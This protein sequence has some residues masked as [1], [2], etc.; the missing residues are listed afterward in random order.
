M[1]STLMNELEPGILRRNSPNQLSNTT[2]AAS[3]LSLSQCS[4]P[5]VEAS[6]LT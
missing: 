5:P 2:R 4:P 6:W 3:A 1:F